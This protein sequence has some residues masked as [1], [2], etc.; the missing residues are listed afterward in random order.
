MTN[1]ST[2]RHSAV[3]IVHDLALYRE[4]LASLIGR[5]DHVSVAWSASTLA[6]AM[7]SMARAPVNLVLLSLDSSDEVD[8][9]DALRTLRARYP[10]VGVL[11]FG[12]LADREMAHAVHA[13]GAA[14]AVRS[15]AGVTEF[16]TAIRQALA[17]NIVAAPVLRRR[18]TDLV[19]HTLSPSH[20]ALAALSVREMQVLQEIRQGMTNREIALRL[21]IS[22]STVNKHVHTVLG[23][24]G[25][26][27]RVHAAIIS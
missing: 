11:A 15:D 2:P 22:I 18:R 5:L 8:G 7:R 6:G 10:E 26:R 4:G 21:G 13:S 17:G 9:H 23:K 12:A 16:L 14:G 3:G 25:A 24:L 19:A 27:N 1:G 20:M